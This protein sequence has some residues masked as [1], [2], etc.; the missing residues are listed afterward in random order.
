MN[1]HNRLNRQPLLLLWFSFLLTALPHLS[2]L[3]FWLWPL[4]LVSGLLRYLQ[5][6][7]Q[8]WAQAR[9]LR[10]LLVVAVAALVISSTQGVFGREAGITLLIAMIALKFLESQQRRDG[11]LIVLLT[12]FLASSHFLYRQ[13][14]NISLYLLP[15]LLCNGVAL[16]ALYNPQQ[17]WPPRLKL[18]FSLSLQALP[19]MFLLFLLFPRISGPL[20]GLSNSENR[21]SSGL[22]ESMSPGNIS[23]L[24][25]SA[26]TVFRVNFATNI[27]K[28]N[29]RYWRGPILW[30]FDG[31]TWRA[32]N[33]RPWEKTQLDQLADPIDYQLAL[34]PHY[35]KWLLALDITPHAPAG[36]RLN[37]NAQLL[38]QKSIQ[39]AQ[40]YTLRS[41]LSYRL[42]LQLPLWQKT[43]ALQL[44]QQL[45]PKTAALARS[46]QKISSDPNILVKSALNYF[47][48]QNF[49]YTLRPPPL[50]GKH[51]IDDFL[52]NSRRGFCEHYASSFVVLM[53]SIGIP[54]RVVTGYMGGSMNQLGNYL[55]VRQWDAHAWA[56]V[57]LEGKGWQRVDPT[58]AVAP[59][60]VEEG[61]DAAL[62]AEERRSLGGRQSGLFKQLN[63][64][65]DSM[66]HHWN[67]WV[68][69]YD[70]Q[71]QQHFLA[72]FGLKNSSD[73]VLALSLGISTLLA[74]LSLWFLRQ[75]RRQKQPLS[76]KAY[77]L[78]RKKAAKA[79]VISPL[80]EGPQH[81]Q[82]RL[83]QAF[84]KQKN[85]LEALFQLFIQLRY[86]KKGGHK[87]AKRFYQ[88]VKKLRLKR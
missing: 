43:L 67:R 41:Y 47:N 37:G 65:W 77:T 51:E 66:N 63:F 14:L 42:D 70:L 32:G 55:I 56:E 60:R 78:L 68:V 87:D 84:P 33:N 36:T 25:R 71:Q 74:L 50:R 53:R 31:H 5:Y 6:K 79:G 58:A 17:N 34:E 81:F 35:K 16:L 52:F 69:G 28:A 57:W 19:I 39:Q 18:L 59:E 46:W 3:T 8:P 15:V 76:L 13:D 4:L 20:W 86:Q 9:S 29:Q 45:N 48:Q 26:K 64:F 83:C 12:Y 1:K 82:Q 40:Q 73:A 23:Q 72:H 24:T 49:Y 44:P 62:S 30:H 10:L 38:S 2:Q 7:K 85:D 21:A 61:I 75:R 88:Q 27:P 22:S 11:V 54:A 80:N